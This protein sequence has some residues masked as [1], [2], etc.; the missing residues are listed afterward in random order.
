MSI[1]SLCVF[2]SGPGYS[3]GCDKIRNLHG[4]DPT[5]QNMLFKPKHRSWLGLVLFLS[6]CGMAA[7]HLDNIYGTAAIQ[8][9]MVGLETAEG[10]LFAQQV[11]PIL[12]NRCVVCH[13]CN[14]APCQLKLSSPEGIDRGYSRKL[15]YNG[16][17]LTAAMPTRLF[18]DAQSTEEWRT[19]G[20]SP[21]LNER[22]QSVEANLQSGLMSRI[23]QLKQDNPLPQS[24]ILPAEYDFSL[25][26]AQVCHGIENFT[27]FANVHPD[28]G[29]PYGLPGL[30]D[31]E[32]RQL[33]GWLANG[34]KMSTPAPLEDPQQQMVE[35]WESFLNQDSNKHRL[36]SRYIYEHLFL[37]HLYFSEQPGGTFFSIV[38]SRTAPGQVL[39]RITTLRP[40]DDPGVESFYYRLVREK[41]TILDKTH[42]PYLMDKQRMARWQTLFIDADF[43]IDTLPGYQAGSTSNPFVTYKDF[44]VRTRY[45]FLLDDAQLFIMGFIKGAACRGSIALSVIDDRFWVF[46]V[47]PDLVNEQLHTEFLEVQGN[48]LRLPDEKGSS[49]SIFTWRKY[50]KLEE[51]Y[52]KA[53]E[54]SV[55]DKLRESPNLLN[56]EAVWD[57]ESTNTNASLTVFRH[58]DNASVVQGLVGEPPK[59]AWIMDYIQFERIHYLLVAGF[60]PFGNT[61]HQLSTRLYMD[62][63]RFE[64][65]F[66]F[67]AFLPP[68]NRFEELI[69]WY[70]NADKGIQNFIKT[71]PELAFFPT[72]IKYQTTDYKQELYQQL[73]QHL[74]MVIPHNYDLS[75]SN[76][77]EE[78]LR[79]LEQLADISGK[80]TSFLPE[81]VFIRLTD[82]QGNEHFYTLIHNRGFLNVTS[83]LNQANNRLPDE[84]NITLV[85]GFIGAYPNAFWDVR[86]TDLSDLSNRVRTLDSESDYKKLMDNYGVRR[87][88]DQFWAFSDRLHQEHRNMAQVEAG[89]FDFSRLEN[90]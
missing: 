9:R 36:M 43:E 71:M 14:D 33:Q 31:S 84:D 52:F 4:L 54:K 63:L 87:T 38:R 27:R 68:G 80:T 1:L 29:M 34:A 23:L 69:Y 81:V 28:L 40:Y 18:E 26:R 58:L 44:P 76:V 74:S 65:E 8:D 70:R 32:Y 53:K 67:V 30:N 7:K 35:T 19:K 77:S 39:D 72:G 6:G 57:G 85:T 17:R 41:A 48:N 86:S 79:S 25:D 73:R 90:R 47:S 46:F 3:D 24:D 16:T 49:A 22:Q 78:D 75:A 62:F 42:I 88:S 59:T 89:L 10:E 61:G 2:S 45:Q 64:G 66:N 12:D 51:Q 83:L 37:Q 60:D 5:L 20:F 21:V 11:K 55:S 50:A 15:V 56:L 82:I 13:S